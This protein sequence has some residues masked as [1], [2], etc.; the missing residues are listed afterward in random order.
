M[1]RHALWLLSMTTFSRVKR[2]LLCWSWL[3]MGGQLFNSCTFP[4][5]TWKLETF[6]NMVTALK[7]LTALLSDKTSSSLP[8]MASR[9]Y[10]SSNVL[11]QEQSGDSKA[12]LDAVRLI[13]SWQSHNAQMQTQKFCSIFR[14]AANE[15]SSIFIPALRISRAG[16]RYIST[17]GMEDCV[18][19]PLLDV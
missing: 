13:F 6:K 1:C 11:R 18:S 14:T 16:K 19:N 10:I 2:A 4:E 7:K 9:S 17:W 8:V 15:Y 5:V 3:P 12:F